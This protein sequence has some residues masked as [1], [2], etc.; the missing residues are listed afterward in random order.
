M[1]SLTEPNRKGS[2][3]RVVAWSSF[4]VFA[5]VSIWLERYFKEY[6][7]VLYHGYAISAWS[8]SFRHWPPEYPA[9]SLVLFLAPLLLPF[10]YKLGFVLLT[11]VAL[12]VMLHVG[13][14]R[15][16]AIWGLKVVGYLSLGTLLLFT[17][18]YDIF[19]ALVAFLAI[20]QAMQRHWRWA[21]VWSIL[22][23]LLKLWPAVLW[24]IFLIVEYRETGRIRWKGLALGV[25]AEGV[26]V[27][28]Q[29]ITSPHQAFG[30][31]LYLLNRPIEFESLAASVTSIIGSPHAF[32]SFGSSN[33]SD[34]GLAHDVSFV[35]T[36]L[37]IAAVSSV[38]WALW[39]GRLDLVDAA[40]L[41]LGIV[42]LT[43]KVFSPQYLIWLAPWLA[44]RRSN[45]FLVLAFLTTTLGYI[46]LLM[47]EGI[48]HIIIIPD[49]RNASLILGLLI[50]AKEA[51]SRQASAQPTNSLEISLT[52]T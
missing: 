49:V 27:G 23:F 5:I 36:L 16:G 15:N 44:L 46:A 22:G 45:L 9:L 30:S 6:S 34:H 39:K 52:D 14:R 43:S 38:L 28:V 37:G 33:I 51:L 2:Q 8:S 29:E 21:W 19:P 12:G 47:G 4:S 11:L 41:C 10:T 18:R 35:I 32:F 13:M 31:F 20:D 42:L 7:V 50:F 25:V 17:R 48:L 3:S 26:S 1:T 24:P 40:I